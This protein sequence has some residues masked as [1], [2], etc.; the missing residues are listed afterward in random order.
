[1]DENRALLLV[2]LPVTGAQRERIL[3]AAGGRPV[4]FCPK[5]ELEGA[6][7]TKAEIVFGNLPPE[8]LARAEGL[9]WLQLNSAGADAY[10]K[11]GA[12]APGVALTTAVGAYG[13]TVSE[14][15]LAMLLSMNRRLPE[16]EENQKNALWRPMGEVRSVEGATILILGLGNIGGDFARKVKALGA[17]TIGIRRKTGECPAYLDEMHPLDALDAVLPRADV[18]AI[19]LPLTG[20]TR[21]LFGDARFARMKPGALLMNIGR[22]PIVETDALLRA[23]EKGALGGAC[24]DVT[25]PEPL[26]A[27]HPLWRQERVMITPHVAGQFYLPETKNRVVGIFCENLGRYQAGLP[28]RNRMERPRGG[29]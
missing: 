13:L 9:R 11:P 1:M 2:T 27:D 26:P 21:G 4:L 10:M 6:D 18:A 23:L 12:L 15:M 16:Y 20:E 5:E 24:L 8:M 14:H 22:G 17:Y 19:C 7:W 3:S 25:D 28:L 29:Q